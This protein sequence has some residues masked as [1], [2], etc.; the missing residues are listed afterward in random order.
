MPPMT[1]PYKDICDF[2]P[3]YH[4][5][6]FVQSQVILQTQI[7]FYEHQWLKWLVRVRHLHVSSQYSERKQ[8]TCLLM[9]RQG[10][11]QSGIERAQALTDISRSA[12]CCHSN[13][14]GAP[15]ANPPKLHNY[16]ARPTIPPSYLWV[17]ARRAVCGDGQTDT[18]T[19]TY[20]QTDARDQHTFRVVYDSREM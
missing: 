7:I 20:I 10:Q 8:N 1:G 18:K 14:T 13:E 3:V 9:Y 11:D 19:H 5:K 15:I 6:C 12:L 4:V 2:V 17:R 16:G